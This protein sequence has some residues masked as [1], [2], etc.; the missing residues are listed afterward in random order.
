MQDAISRRGFLGLAGGGAAGLALYDLAAWQKPAEAASGGSAS[1]ERCGRPEVPKREFRA[2]WV[3][4]VSNIDWPSRPGLP[5]R[6]QK[7][8]LLDILDAVRSLGMNAVILQVRPAA[9]ALYPSRYAPWS[10]YLTG[11]QGRSP[12]YDPLAFAVEEAHRRGLELHAWFNPYRVSTGS[13]LRGLSP[14]SPA[15]EHPGWVVRYGGRLYFDPGIPGVRRL[16]ERSVMEVVGRYDVDAVHLDDYFYPYPVSG[17][18]FPDGGTF[19][20]YGGRFR[21]KAA[22]RRNNVDLLV[23]GLSRQ[24][25]RKKRYVKF[26][27]SPFGIW[28]NR[29]EDPR[30]S[31]TSGLSSYD[32]LY[33]DS[34]G[35]VRRGWLDYVV[36][37][38]YWNFGYGPAPYEVLVRWWAEQ[39]RGRGVELYIGQAAYKI[40]SGG[41]WDDPNEMPSHV[42]FDRRHPGVRGDVYF[43]VSDVLKNPLGFRGRL[44]RDLY[45]HPALIPAMRR[46]GGAPPHPV[47]LRA[48]NTRRGVLLEWHARGR[49]DD[50]LYVVYRFGG[51]RRPGACDLRDGRNILKVVPAGRSG[52]RSCFDRTARPGRRYTYCVSAVDRLHHESPPG[53]R[54][55]ITVR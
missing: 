23:G 5:A 31:A 3:A 14:R 20:R 4:S 40:G 36:P 33:A 21:S 50:A 41:A 55:V 22:W 45:R 19:R 28:R 26:G 51:A 12:G 6:R 49:P 34:R 30:G 37:Q 47:L 24:I 29:S 9:D 53:G 43:S 44:A 10:S 54:A 1:P 52:T 42:R 18:G 39:V 15:R 17:E 16:I 2:V 7:R 35:W 25:K 27:I 46:P 32:D 48:R 13:S 38:V 8:E 11:R